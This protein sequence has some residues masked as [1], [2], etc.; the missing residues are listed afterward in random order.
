[1]EQNAGENLHGKQ[2]QRESAEVVPDFLRMKRYALLGD[3]LLDVAEIQPLVEPV[4][5]LLHH[6]DYARETT[7]SASLPSPRTLTVNRSSPRGGGPETTL[8]P[9]SYVPL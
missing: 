4:N 8:P 7:I 9:R 5:S 6:D 2:E 1:E 3:E